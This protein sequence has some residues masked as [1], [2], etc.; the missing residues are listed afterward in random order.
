MKGTKLLLLTI[1]LFLVLALPL[2]ACI[3]GDP[4][5]TSAPEET[6]EEATEAPEITDEETERI[7]AE[8]TFADETNE[9]MSSP[10][11][12]FGESATVEKQTANEPLTEK[13]ESDGPVTEDA[14]NREPETEEF[15]SKVLET[16]EPE[17]ETEEPETEE[18]ETEEPETETEVPETEEPHT[19]MWGEWMTIREPSCTEEGLVERSCACGETETAALD[20]EGHQESDWMI[21]EEPA[22]EV[23]G[24]RH[25]ECIVCHET[26]REEAIPALEGS[27]GLVFTSN[28]DGTCYVSGVGTCTDVDV[29]LPRYSPDKDLVTG[30]GDRAFWE[31]KIMKTILIHDSVRSIGEHAFYSCSN[32]ISIHIPASVSSIGYQ[33]FMIGECNIKSITVDENNPVYCSDG[34]CLI[35]TESK[36]LIRGCPNSKIPSDGSVEVIGEHAFASCKSYSYGLKNIDIPD[37]VKRIEDYAFGW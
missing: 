8:D 16:E 5:E 17:T 1:L 25:T 33:A 9:E 21:D 10:S 2:T 11:D 13:N 23:E 28:G 37:T 4:R 15:E 31:Y 20:A 12:P 27:R 29:I 26:V 24:H 7:T 14:E 6:T 18:P 32:L 3:E 22:Y 36:V 19:H 30:I 35:E 34:N